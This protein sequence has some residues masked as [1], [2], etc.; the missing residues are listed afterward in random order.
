[1]YVRGEAPPLGTPLCYSLTDVELARKDALGSGYYE[2]SLEDVC[3]REFVDSLVRRTRLSVVSGEEREWYE[4]SKIVSVFIIV[5]SPVSFGK[6][7]LQV[8]T[9]TNVAKWLAYEAI[10]TI[11]NM[12]MQTIHDVFHQEFNDRVL[13]MISG[14]DGVYRHLVDPILTHCHA[15]GAEDG[16]YHR[17][18]AC[19]SSVLSIFRAPPIEVAVA[20]KIPTVFLC[21]GEV[22][23][24]AKTESLL[25]EMREIF[26]DQGRRKICNHFFCMNKAARNSV[27]CSEICKDMSGLTNDSCV[28]WSG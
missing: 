17:F 8:P 7:C 21:C 16:G 2:H 28:Y 9:P 6:L 13:T 3:T 11:R 15:C 10:A 27:F 25:Q 19:G 5:Y 24:R 14:R 26:L 4:C 23:C 22:E 20:L 1:M 12:H 18:F